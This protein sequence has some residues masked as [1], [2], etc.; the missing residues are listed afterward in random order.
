M[1]P[2]R[3]YLICVNR[4]VCEAVNVLLRREGITLLGMETDAE[5]ALAQVCALNPS[6]ILVEGNGAGTDAALMSRLAQLVY[7]RKNLCVIRLSMSD[8]QLH[9][10]H[11]EQRRLV[12]T[13]DLIQAIRSTSGSVPFEPSE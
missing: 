11:Q 3:V 8:G 13:Q 12:T 7:E 5:L 6:V 9:I 2:P 10:Y 4:L 1:D